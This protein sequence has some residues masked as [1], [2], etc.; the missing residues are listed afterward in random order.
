MTPRNVIY[1]YLLCV[2][3]FLCGIFSLCSNL[4]SKFD[5]FT[6]AETEKRALSLSSDFSTEDLYDI[7]YKGG[8]ITDKKDARLAAEWIHDKKQKEEIPNLGKL[9]KDEFK[10]PAL[11]ALEKGG[12]QTILR[13]ENEFY[14]LGQDQEWENLSL[15]SIQSTVGNESEANALITVKVNSKDENRKTS[16]IPVRLR[17]HYKKRT[18]IKTEKEDSTFTE[19][20]ESKIVAWGK[21]DDKGVVKFYVPKNHF[22]SVVPINRGYQYGREK[23]TTSTA[24]NEAGLNCTFSEKAHSITPISRSVF[25]ELKS[26]GALTAR[27]PSD[28]KD[29]LLIGCLIYILG[30]GAVLLYVLHTDYRLKTSSDYLLIIVLMALTGI[31]MFAWFSITDSLTDIAHGQSMS[32]YLGIGLLAFTALYSVNWNKFYHGQSKYMP[33][34]HFTWLFSIAKNKG[35]VFLGLALVLFGLLAVFGKGPEGSA[36][37]VNLGPIQPSE[38]CKFLILVFMAAFFAD[39]YSL[40]QKFSEK[41]TGLTVKRKLTIMSLIA[42]TMLALMGVY[43]YLSDGGP[44]LV[45]LFTFIILYSVVRRDLGKMLIGVLT[46]AACLSIARMINPT[47]IYLYAA[48]VIWLFGWILYCI[49]KHTIYESAILAN[50]IPFMFIVMNA[51]AGGNEGARL[52]NRSGMAWDGVWDNTVLG[53]DQIAQGLWGVAS[54]GF[55][56]MGLGNGSP[57]SIPACHTDM[58]FLSVGEML[59]FIGLILVVL[60]MFALIH[61]TLLIGRKAGNP[62]VMFFVMGL[63]IITGVQF[64]IIVFGSLGLLP[65]TGINVPFLS[66]G[67]VSLVVMLAVYGVALSASRLKT[68]QAQK[69]N[70]HKFQGAVTA[71]AVLFMAGALTIVCTLFKYQI[72]DKNETIIRPAFITNNEGARIVEYNPR[73]NQILRRI[74]SGNIYDRNGLLLATSSRDSLSSQM[75]AL[76]KA[77]LDQRA[78][79]ALLAMGQKRYYPFGDHMLFML[80]DANTKQVYSYYDSDPI[81]YMA[82]YRHLTDLRGLEIPAKPKELP[83]KKYKRNRFMEEEEYTFRTHE[84]DYTSLLPFLQFGIN[85]NPIIER[86]NNKRDERDIVLSVDAVLQMKL[87]NALQE[88]VSNPANGLTNLKRLRASVV[89]LDSKNGDLLS[90]A[91]YPLPNQDSIIMLNEKRI[92]GD[93]PFERIPNHSPITE[94]DLGLTFQTQPGSTAKVMSAM[95]ALMKEGESSSRTIYTVYPQERIEKGEAEPKGQVSMR[96][97]IVKSS[98]CYF[99]NLVHDKNLYSELDTLYKSIGIR[100]HHNITGKSQTPY[101]FQIGELGSTSEFTNILSD[102]ENLGVNKYK[103]Y[104]QNNQANGDYKKM[105]WWETGVAWGQGVLRATPLNMARVASIVANNGEL[106]PTRYVLRH[107]KKAIAP[108]E[109]IKVLDSSSAMALKSYMQQESDKHR[110]NGHQLPKNAV[111][112]ERMGGKTGTPERVDRKGKRPNDAWY[113]C[114][115]ESETNGAPL[116]IALRFERSEGYNS[117]LAVRLMSKVVIPTLNATNYKLK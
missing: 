24:L 45:L 17:E 8:Y 29:I 111:E 99:I 96:D 105:N 5:E 89:V 72:L 74:E 41:A 71:G 90:S 13:V 94:R 39:R 54:G 10:I 83:S 66:Q 93:A 16:N 88:Y 43:F 51:Y 81:G 117:G 11:T 62:F 60:C 4:S 92:F 58:A 84:Y 40:I 103:N 97:A 91:N 23:G 49:K 76:I 37:K 32:L 57:A 67:G 87:Q 110:N 42:F 61:R 6:K 70:A 12:D 65:L 75:D 100:V 20:I 73:I 53:G 18:L 68:T 22:Y 80:G 33:K 19:E 78:L 114:F 102:V 55:T 63:G 116:A 115:I 14:N 38:I 15:D 50:L 27:T 86:H 34:K 104:I 85:K 59:G 2:G 47:K 26:D 31:G 95:S 112:N 69:E 56:G 101:Y 44:A 35:W 25:Y 3:V 46:F 79:K 77:G 107:G 106:A 82:E 1:G 7:F 113:I 98:N 21:T 36:A 109:K 30:W 48:A 108:F 64:L 28:F 9:L 52:S